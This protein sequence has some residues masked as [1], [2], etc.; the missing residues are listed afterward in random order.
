M[1][2]KTVTALLAT[3]AKFQ[4]LYFQG[5]AEMNR[6]AVVPALASVK[7]QYRNERYNALPQHI[8]A[9]NKRFMSTLSNLRSNG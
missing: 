4:G 7:R 3:A 5:N 1:A 9:S 2:N 8:I 6:L